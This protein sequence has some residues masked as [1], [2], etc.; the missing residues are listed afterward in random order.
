MKKILCLILTLVLV[1]S[2]TTTAFAKKA[3][4]EDEA[5]Q[6][7]NKQTTQQIISKTQEKKKTT[8]VSNS[9]IKEQKKTFK[10]EGTSVIKYGKYKLPISPVTK[11][12]GATVTYDKTTAVLTVVKGTITIVIDFKNKTVTVNGVADTTSSIF[13]VKNSRKT[14]VLIKYIAKALGVR[15]S[16]DDD[17]VEIEIPGLDYP[18]NVVVTP[19]GTKVLANTLNTTTLFMTA[20]ANI[21]AGQATGGKAE[22]YVGTKLVATDAEIIATDATVTFTTSDSTPINAELQTLIPQGGA[23]TVKLY[24]AGGQSV[25]SKVNNP[26]LTVDYAAPTIYN[27]TNAIYNVTGSSILLTVSGAS[28]VGDKVDVT[29]ITLYDTALAK[30]YQLTNSAVTGS[31]GVVSDSTLLTINLGPADLLGL[32]G[33]AVSTVGMTI[34]PGALLMDAAGNTSAEFTTIQTMPVVVIK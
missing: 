22:L 16:V 25:S 26:T 10:I 21:K 7:V 31:T 6:K 3:D 30:S 12:M 5:K 33:Y 32:A 8:K 23:V 15:A 19:V 18:T 14:T 11:G 9:K 2:T 28:I 4:K 17:K 13:T 29:K 20:S 27:V 34:A 1:L 24:N